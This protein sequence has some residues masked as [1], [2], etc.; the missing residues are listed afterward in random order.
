[1]SRSGERFVR[2]TEPKDRNFRRARQDP[3]LSEEFR[4]E[5]KRAAS[6]RN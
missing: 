3:A 4:N 5:C 2:T 1:M 6:A